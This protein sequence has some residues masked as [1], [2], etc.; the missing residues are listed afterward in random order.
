M[1]LIHGT[2][3]AH[4]WC[5]VGV[6]SQY[7]FSVVCVRVMGRVDTE[8]RPTM[9]IMLLILYAYEGVHQH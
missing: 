1:F 2:E 4:T 7:R 8:Y 5:N 6:R 9:G 3:E